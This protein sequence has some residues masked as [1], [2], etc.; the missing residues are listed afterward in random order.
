MFDK[1]TANVNKKVMNNKNTKLL[2]AALEAFS[3]YGIKRATMNDIASLADVSRQTIYSVYATKDEML[4]AAIIFWS[5]QS[6]QKIEFAW[7]NEKRLDVKLDAFFQ[8]AVI[9][10]FEMMTKLPESEAMILGSNSVTKDALICANEGH[11]D[12]LCKLLKPYEKQIEK[13]DQTL[14]QFA[15]FVQKSSSSVKHSSENLEELRVFLKS[16]KGTILA[17]CEPK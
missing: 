7:K 3:R 12:D 15:Q 10:P 17:I 16:L 13:S 1:F 9:E 6:R 2:S 5:E 14:Q 4:Y 11:L 8:F